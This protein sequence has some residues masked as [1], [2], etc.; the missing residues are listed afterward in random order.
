MSIETQQKCLCALEMEH[1]KIYVIGAVWLV[2]RKSI[3]LYGFA[4]AEKKLV[5][6]WR[7]LFFFLFSILNLLIQ[8]F[9]Q[10][11]LH[12][13]NCNEWEIELCLH[14]VKLFSLQILRIW[15]TKF[16]EELKRALN[17]FLYSNFSEM[18]QINSHFE[19]FNHFIY[20][21]F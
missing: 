2:L 10:S 15:K 9:H 21:A 18:K 1:T 4:K 11:W 20:F 12:S 17:G 6:K 14:S 19:A 8:W 13:G 5:F 16:C 7:S 3:S